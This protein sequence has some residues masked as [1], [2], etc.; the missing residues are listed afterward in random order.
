MCGVVTTHPSHTLQLH[1]G[2]PAEHELQCLPSI[3][4]RQRGGGGGARRRWGN[5]A[6]FQGCQYTCA[7]CILVTL[8]THTVSTCRLYYRTRK[9]LVLPMKTW[10]SPGNQVCVWGGGNPSLPS[11]PPSPPFLP[12][13]P[14]SFPPGLKE[15]MEKIVK[16]KK[17]GVCWLL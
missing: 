6:S 3:L 4:I 13:L 14:P 8:H 2:R 9:L 15:S 7:C 16:R 12:H 5:E 10:R 11:F 1:Q 17:T